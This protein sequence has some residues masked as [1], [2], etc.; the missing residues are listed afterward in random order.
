MDGRRNNSGKKGNKGGG[1]PSKSDERKLIEKLT[2]MSDLAHGQLNTALAAG[3][4]WA[5]KLWF[6][7]F[8]GKPKQSLDIQ[9]EQKQTIVINEITKK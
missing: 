7:Y 4:Q 8:Y 5:V 1:R 2:P 9:G 6:E 3:E